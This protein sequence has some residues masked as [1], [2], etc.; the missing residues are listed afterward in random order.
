[1]LLFLCSSSFS[2]CC[3]FPLSNQKSSSLARKI[4]FSLL[5]TQQK[6]YLSPTS[7]KSSK[8]TKEK[9][10]IFKTLRVQS[11]QEHKST[12]LCVRY[13]IFVRGNSIFFSSTFECVSVR[14][15]PGRPELENCCYC[16]CVCNCDSCTTFQFRM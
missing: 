10:S 14:L 12:M 3:N 11:T 13:L 2:V 1:M 5:S 16:L 7:I 15:L 6:R 9:C 8:Y 4:V